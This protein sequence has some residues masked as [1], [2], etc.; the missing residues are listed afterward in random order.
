MK[1]QSSQFFAH[2][3]RSYRFVL[4]RCKY[5][6][7]IGQAKVLSRYHASVS[8]SKSEYHRLYERGATHR[9]NYDTPPLLGNCTE[10]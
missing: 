9:M 5:F 1:E 6:N 7:C 8:I 3:G 4:H 10:T 2:F